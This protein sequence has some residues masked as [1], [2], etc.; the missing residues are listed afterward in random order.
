ME[1]DFSKYT[2]PYCRWHKSH[3]WTHFH[4][5]EE[6]INSQYLGQDF[7]MICYLDTKKIF[8]AKICNK[9]NRYLKIRTWIIGILLMVF[10][11]CPVIGFLL[12]LIN[13]WIDYSSTGIVGLYLFGIGFS[14]GGVLFLFWILWKIIGPARAH[15][16]F[17]RA[18]KCNAL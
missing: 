5:E 10:T 11:V 4:E 1:K 8:K 2:C 15:V 18:S 14:S 13:N 3:S 12:L 17:D 7:N 9:C 16:S 6:V